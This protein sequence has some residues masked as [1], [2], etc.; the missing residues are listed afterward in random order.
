[1]P[2]TGCFGPLADGDQGARMLAT[3]GGIIDAGPKEFPDAVRQ[4]ADP[5][6]TFYRYS[7]SSSLLGSR[8][9]ENNMGKT[10]TIDPITRLEG[11]GK[12]DIHLTDAGD[13]ERAFFQVPE[14]RGFEAFCLGRP[15][16]AMPQITSRICGVC[17]TA[18]HMA[19]V[20]ALDMIFGVTPPRTARLIREIF[21]HLFMFEDHLLHFY[22]LGGPDFIVGPSAPGKNAIFSALSRPSAL[23]P[24]K[25][26]SRSGNGAA[27]S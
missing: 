7:L 6:G 20:K 17:P 2:C 8:R 14:L 16:E 1:M 19:A 5:A 15:A 22:F 13:V 11:H 27:N 24:G 21:Y 3:L 26:S 25:K 9:K 23:R 12:I 10:I 4:F 18:H